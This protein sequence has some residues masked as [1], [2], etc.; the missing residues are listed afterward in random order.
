MSKARVVIVGGGFAGLR[1]AKVLRG[2]DVELTVLDRC[3]HHLFQPLLYQVATAGLS[4]ANIAVPIRSIVGRASNVEVLLANVERVELA[5]RRVV[6][7]GGQTLGY[8]YLLIA[9]GARHA[10]FGHDEWE[11]HAPGLKTLDD[12]TEIRR[13]VLTAFERAERE[14]DSERRQ[15]YLTFVLVGGGPTGVELAGAIAE[16]ARYTLARDFRKAQLGQTRVLLVEA[17]P[18]ILPMLPESLSAKAR[19]ALG[20]LNVE[21]LE[22]AAVTDVTAQGVQLG[23]RCIAAHTVVWAAGVSA[24]PL[25]RALGVEVDRSG[26]VRVEPDLSLPG[27]PEVFVAGDLARVEEPDG[28]LVPGVAP[29]A[30]QEGRRAAQNILLR[31]RQQPTQPFRYVDKGTL[32]T[33]GR[34]AAVAKVGK[35]ELWG[36]T[37]WLTWLVVHIAYLI[38][39]KNRL[40]V[41]LDWAWNFFTYGRGTRLIFG[42]NK[43][44]T[45]GESAAPPQR[46]TGTDG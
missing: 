2:K 33:I 1:A 15:A 19:A 20:K 3:N 38:G 17:G 4:P 30:M 25:G 7:D 45:R 24:S 11:R 21:V 36:L 13:R 44:L 28:S 10:Y 6:L 18:R 41:L 27:H 34:L 39:F 9:S 5:E 43:Q 37:A 22:N 23:E 16:L 8:D 26:R 40:F 12:A 46:K 31:L 32:A 42:Y 14:P 35:L 29:A